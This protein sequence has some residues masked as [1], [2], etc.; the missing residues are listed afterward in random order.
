MTNATQRRTKRRFA[1]ELYPPADEYETRSLEVEVPHLYAIA[2]G[3]NVFG[4]D[5][6]DLFHSD[7]VHAT[8]LV[9]QRTS[10]LVDARRFALLADA[11]HQGMTG[12][13]AWDWADM[14]A[15]DES[16]E[17]VG[18]RARHYG[19]PFDAIKP[20]PVV[21]EAKMHQHYSEPDA[22]G[23]R[24]LTERVQMPESQCPDCTEPEDADK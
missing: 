8:R 22:H 18:D 10:Q 17:F 19:I 16:G 2:I 24:R 3:L 1:H 5:W 11:I 23:W 6:F 12:Q 14:R 15:W 9:T 21:A 4:T 13:E 20:Y 7:Y